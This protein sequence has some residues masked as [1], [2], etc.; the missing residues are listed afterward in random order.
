M[1]AHRIE[2]R[3]REGAVMVEAV[4]VASTF[5]LLLA[6]LAFMHRF[7]LAAIEAQKE[8]RHQ[9][10]TRAL[11]GCVDNDMSLADAV[12]ALRDGDLPIPSGISGGG[13]AQA[14]A[15]RSVPGLFN[16]GD[17]LVTSA[18]S[19]PCNTRVSDVSASSTGGWLMDMF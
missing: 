12:G 5:V 18:V 13:T 1:R 11:Q 6:V 3:R 14:S 4:M 16:R 19:M 17:K 9:A 10:Y 2:L 7:A 15:S 8:A